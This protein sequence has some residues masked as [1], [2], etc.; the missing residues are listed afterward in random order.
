M[1][2]LVT[3]A[4]RGSFTLI[5][6]SEDPEHNTAAALYEYLSELEAYAPPEL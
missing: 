2:Q 1:I 5:H 6:H 4:R 3:A